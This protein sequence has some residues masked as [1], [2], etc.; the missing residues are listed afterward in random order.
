MQGKVKSIAKQVAYF[1]IK[2]Y[3]DELIDKEEI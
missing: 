3:I 2:K 1:E